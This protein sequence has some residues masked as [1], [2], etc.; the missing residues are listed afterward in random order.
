MIRSV[1]QVRS[2]FISDIHLGCRYSHAED[3]Q[4]FLQCHQPQYLY[5]VGDIIDGWRLKR[6][7]YWNDS[8][9]DLIRRMLELL[10][11]GTVIRYAPGNHDEFLRKFIDHLGSVE[12]ADEFIHTTADDQRLLVMHG[13]QFDAV[14]RN[15]RLLSMVGDVG[16]DCLLV[17]NQWFNAL[18]RLMGRRYWSLSGFIKTQVKRATCFIGQF[19]DVVTKHAGARGCSGVICGHI[20]TPTVTERNGVRYFNTGDWVENCTAL[21]EHLDGSFELVANFDRGECAVPKPHFLDMVESVGD[22]QP[23]GRL[24]PFISNWS[25]S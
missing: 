21:I 2:I 13:D 4:W 3:L 1:K 6:G 14:V 17:L 19:E 16:Y 22:E 15:A 5:L 7:W 12:I 23:T 10:K 11:R 9:S 25:R 24:Y 8:Y 18:R 20:H